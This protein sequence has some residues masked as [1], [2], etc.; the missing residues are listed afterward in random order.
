MTVVL[1]MIFFWLA[2]FALLFRDTLLPQLAGPSQISAAQRQEL[3][4]RKL[5]KRREMNVRLQAALADAQGKAPAAAGEAK[6]TDAAAVGKTAEPQ[7]A[8]TLNA[9]WLSILDPWGHLVARTR[10][11]VIGD[12]WLALP[13][14]A[15]YAGAQWIFSRDGGGETEVSGGL[16]RAGEAV[17]LWHLAANVAPGEGLSLAAWRD[18]APL[19]WLSLESMNEFPDVRLTPGKQQGDYL[20]CATPESIREFGVFIQGNSIVGWSFG[21]WLGHVYLWNGKSEL[22]L[23]ADTD[24]RAFYSATFANG[25]EEKFAMALA[26]KGGHAAD[27]KRL[28]GLIEG[29]AV[30]PKLALED[31]PEYLR[32]EEAAKLISQLSGQLI[33]AGQGQQ[34]VGIMTDDILREIGDIKLLLALIPAITAS[35]GF[36]PAIQKIETVGREL[37]EKG[38]VNVPAVNDQHL[39]LYQDWLQ[40]LVTV[41]AVS[42]GS[43]VL[44]KGK[45]FYPVDPYLHLLGVELALLGNDW[46]EAER[47]LAMMEYPAKYRDRSELLARRI[48][49]MK[50]DDGAI[51]IRFT[52]GGNRIPL[53][54]SLNQSI[55]QEFLVDTGASMVSIPSETA[56]AL[57]LETVRGAHWDKHSVSTA[58]GMVSASEV[59]LESVEI[60]GW[61]EH[62]VSALVMDIPGQP[63]VGLLGMNYLS[64][65]KMDLNNAEGKLTL[66]PK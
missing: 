42:E 64:R 61:V 65:F 16:W 41:R 15:A 3:E 51:V 43:Q 58:G 19:V 35:H 10:A 53:A 6:A 54:A 55:R 1:A 66:R 11:A 38:G 44:I 59:L 36:E 47:L 23:K 21:P 31:T 13:T 32:P 48:T 34:V 37:V 9:G 26:D 63:G 60:E 45:A 5:A 62:N 56:A 4:A 8:S 25:R 33:Q 7:V 30:K 18:G 12:G 52:A 50:G 20:V 39:K 17:G 28:S 29:F 49:E 27:L 24:V 46:Q 57:R 22:E 2:G 14:R 40:S